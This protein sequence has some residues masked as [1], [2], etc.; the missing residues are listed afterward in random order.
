MNFVSFKKLPSTE[1]SCNFV[2]AISCNGV[3]PF[4]SALIRAPN[5][6]NNLMTLPLSW[7]LKNVGFHYTLI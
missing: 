3:L 6:I 1:I 7:R 4:S 5:F 2:T